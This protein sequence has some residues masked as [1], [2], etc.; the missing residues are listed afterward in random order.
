VWVVDNKRPI[1]DIGVVVILA[2]AIRP[3][4]CKGWGAPHVLAGLFE[5]PNDRP[6]REVGECVSTLYAANVLVKDELLAMFTMKYFHRSIEAW[7]AF[8]CVIGPCQTIC[9]GRRS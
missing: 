6:F 4:V 9:P 2:Q 3:S 8:S 1:A 5:R 7:F